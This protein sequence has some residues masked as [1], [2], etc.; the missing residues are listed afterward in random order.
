MYFINMLI[1]NQMTYDE[2]YYTWGSWAIDSYT[3]INK[4]VGIHQLLY[5]R[6]TLG[7]FE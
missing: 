6:L 1:P 5:A 7:F 3:F 4:I 2:S